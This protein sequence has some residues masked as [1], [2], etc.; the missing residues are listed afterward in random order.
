MEDSIDKIAE[1]ADLDMKNIRDTLLGKTTFEKPK[2]KKRFNNRSEN[3]DETE[4][5]WIEY[6]KT[7]QAMGQSIKVPTKEN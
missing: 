6:E 7:H 1:Y 2:G 4:K 3:W 5:L